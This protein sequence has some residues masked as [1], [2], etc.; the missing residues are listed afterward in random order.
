MRLIPAMTST[1]LAAACAIGPA[2]AA[3]TF[4]E[5]PVRLVVPQAPGGASDT[6]ARIMAQALGQ[7]WNQP[8]VVENR[9]GAGGNIGME[10]VATAGNDG[11][12]LLMSYEGSHA[13]NPAIYKNLSFNVQRDFAPVATLATLPFVAVTRASSGIK[14]LPGLVDAAKTRRVTYG[15]AGNGSVNHLLGEMFNSAAEVKMVHVP[16][17][18][19]APAI[20]DL[21]GGQI[22]VVFTSLPSV[23]GYIDAGTLV[24]LAVTSGKRSPHAPN[25]P[26]IAEQG[27]PSFDVSPWFG[28]FT[29]SGVSADKVDRMNQDIRALLES[30]EIQ[31][32]FAAQGAVTYATTPEQFGKQVDGALERWAEVVKAS[33]AQVE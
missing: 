27:Y 16:Y 32:K 31:Q 30:P 11:H 21:L 9:A 26:T 10:Y 18:G 29:A 15:S 13:I 7:K 12:T 3:E 28:L 2:M 1:M 20:Q 19:A 4:P 17:R 25:I 8:V 22:D 33:G 23:K 14:D 5:K 24:P 6:L